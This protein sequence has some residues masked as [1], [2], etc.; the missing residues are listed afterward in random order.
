MRPQSFS[1]TSSSIQLRNTT[2][3]VCCSLLIPATAHANVLTAAGMHIDFLIVGNLFI[4]LLEGVIVAFYAKTGMWRSIKT[5]IVGNYVSSWIGTFFV[6]G[7]YVDVFVGERISLHNV[8]PMMVLSVVFF[9]VGTLI[10]EWPFYYRLC[11]SMENRMRLSIRSC[12]LAHLASY[13]LL[14]PFYS[15][16]HSIPPLTEDLSLVNNKGAILYYVSTDDGYI[17][18]S[19]LDPLK[20]ELFYSEETLKTIYLASDTSEET[21]SLIGVTLDD[22]EVTIESSFLIA[23]SR[24]KLEEQFILYLR[25]WGDPLKLIRRYAPQGGVWVGEQNLLYAH[26]FITLRKTYRSMVTVLPNSEV[27]F[28]MGSEICILPGGTQ[29]VAVLTRG[30]SPIAVLPELIPKKEVGYEGADSRKDD[31]F[32]TN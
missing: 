24:S 10:I 20:P 18:R 30:L 14:V 13:A 28:G 31:G 19:K 15:S 7:V 1:K 21:Y 23:S 27:V 25:P 3:L 22:R 6:V 17:Y 8:Y 11:K 32:Q 2:F 26:P 16:L 9:F 12:L 4:G 29:R 5:L